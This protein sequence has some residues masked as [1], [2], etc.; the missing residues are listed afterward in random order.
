MPTS[1]LVL[2]ELKPDQLTV[3]G[4]LAVREALERCGYAAVV[5]SEMD[6]AI[7]VLAERQI[8]LIIST[9]SVDSGTVFDFL[10]IIKG[11]GPRETPVIV[12]CVCGS[13]SQDEILSIACKSSGAQYLNV[14]DYQP[15]E[16][17]HELTKRI[18]VLKQQRFA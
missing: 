7:R 16:L 4:L 11:I 3:Q 12:M 18:R 6:V 1:V 2:T 13:M 9:L 5:T 10:S 8:D 17:Q 15:E 14:S